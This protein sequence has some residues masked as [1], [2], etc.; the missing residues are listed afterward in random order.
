MSNNIR[1]RLER[2]E[3]DTD[4]AGEAER[5]LLR[6]ILF[7]PDAFRAA[8]ELRDHLDHL[9]VTRLAPDDLEGHR[10]AGVLSE[11]IVAKRAREA[12]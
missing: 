3:T 9:G 11:T 4:S 12:R 6:E 1:Q 10:L 2:L 5:A 7:D 8:R